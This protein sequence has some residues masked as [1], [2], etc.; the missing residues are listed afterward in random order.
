[1]LAVVVDSFLY[2]LEVMFVFFGEDLA[3]LHLLL[4]CIWKKV[5]DK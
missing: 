4:P 5:G 3:V 2:A 1:M